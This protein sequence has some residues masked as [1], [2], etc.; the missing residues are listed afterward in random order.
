MSNVPL[1]LERAKELVSQVVV[2]MGPDFRYAHAQTQKCY[3]VPYVMANKTGPV[4]DVRGQTGCLIGEVF[5]AHGFTI[6]RERPEAGVV[7]L[8]A[9]FPELFH[10]DLVADYLNIIQVAQD[11]GWTWGDAAGR[12]LEFLNITDRFERDRFMSMTIDSRFP[13]VNNS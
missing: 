2:R 6:H 10:D 1:T 8:Y 7:S 4:P 13:A 3:N 12:G 9:E 11:N 5:T